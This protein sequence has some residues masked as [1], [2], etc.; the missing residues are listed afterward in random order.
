MYS[1]VCWFYCIFTTVVKYILD[2][3]HEY[4]TLMTDSI[5][6]LWFVQI[7]ALIFV[8]SYHVYILCGIYMCEVVVQISVAVEWYTWATPVLPHTK[9]LW[10]RATFMTSQT[11][12][13]ANPF[14]T[15]QRAL[16]DNP[17]DDVTENTVLNARQPRSPTSGSASSIEHYE[18]GTICL[19]Y[20]RQISNDGEVIE[21]PV[22]TTLRLY[23]DDSRLVFKCMQRHQCIATQLPCYYSFVHKKC[24]F[25]TTWNM[26]GNR[27]YLFRNKG[28]CYVYTWEGVTRANSG[29]STSN[30][31]LSYLIFDRH[32]DIRI[33][34]GMYASSY[35]ICDV[36]RGYV[37][38]WILVFDRQHNLVITQKSRLLLL[39]NFIN[40]MHVDC[41]RFNMVCVTYCIL[42]ALL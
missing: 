27:K 20:W 6:H 30:L 29:L 32:H 39:L 17:I 8:S 1:A 15:S 12:V 25:K 7:D 36:K 9:L 21:M 3:D 42:F 31:L 24:H 13:F 38:N 26:Y 37:T 40:M 5:F 2:F 11:V 18:I 19:E 33:M 41:E 16:S 23:C 22:K 28:H 14:V 35:H 10:R 4:F 34:W